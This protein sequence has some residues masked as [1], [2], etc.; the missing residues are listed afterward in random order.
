ME[1]DVSGS[2]KDVRRDSGVVRVAEWDEERE[3]RR[4]RRGS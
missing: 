1:F 2:L 3:T 4:V